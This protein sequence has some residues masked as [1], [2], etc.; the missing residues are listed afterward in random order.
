MDLV[1][2]GLQDGDIS[3][4]DVLDMH[5][6]APR[7]AI[8]FQPDLAGRERPGRQVIDHEIKPD[9][10]RHAIGR[11]SAQEGRAEVFVGELGNRLLDKNL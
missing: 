8:G 4:R 9:P 7:G 6:R 1:A 5:E 10:G 11:R 3:Q 2:L